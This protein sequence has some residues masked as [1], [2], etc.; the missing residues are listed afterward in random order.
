MRYRLYE[1]ETEASRS[2]NRYLARLSVEVGPRLGISY[3]EVSVQ[4]VFLSLRGK[5]F[6]A[7]EELS[8]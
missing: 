7:G 5:E 8:G 1:R 6:A 4:T 2:L 3:V